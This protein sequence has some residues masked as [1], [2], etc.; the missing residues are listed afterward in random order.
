M[1]CPALLGSWEDPSHLP[2]ADCLDC[3][4][5]GSQAEAGTVHSDIPS[6]KKLGYGRGHFCPLPL[7][8]V[9]EGNY[10]ICL[11]AHLIMLF[12]LFDM[13]LSYLCM[14]NPIYHQSEMI[15]DPVPCVAT[16]NAGM[17]NVWT[18]S[19]WG[20]AGDL[21]LLLEQARG[22]SQGEY[23]H[24][25]WSPGEDPSQHPNAGSW[26]AG[27]S[28]S[29]WGNRHLNPLH[30]KTERWVFLSDPS[31]E[32]GE[33]SLRE[34]WCTFVH[35]SPIGL[36]NTSP[37]WISELSDVGVHPLSTGLKSWGTKW[38]VSTHSSSRRSWQ[39]P[40]NYDA[41]SW[42]GVWGRAF[43]Y[44]I[45]SSVGIFSV[46]WY[47]GETTRVVSD[48]VSE[49]IDPYVTLRASVGGGKVGA[50]H[51][52]ILVWSCSDQFWYWPILVVVHYWR[53]VCQSG[54]QFHFFGDVFIFM[55]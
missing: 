53:V 6:R 55:K 25:F 33:D 31:T 34:C 17:I 37:S 30:W 11:C 8:W 32:P 41:L 10:R 28:G 26:E 45:H 12:L 13:V 49:E 14:T 42:S 18:S 52:A 46:A 36:E 47:L 51:A 38:V 3:L 50:S 16:T 1:S 44:P 23:H 4:K 24:L 21:I 39:F 9:Q 15:W 5:L 22:E 35:F 19:F 27:S 40:L 29:S 48:F 7:C 20:E 2:P 43:P 54:S